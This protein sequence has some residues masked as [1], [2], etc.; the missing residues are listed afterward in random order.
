[1]TPLPAQHKKAEQQEGEHGVVLHVQRNVFRVI[2]IVSGP[3][4]KTLSH[5]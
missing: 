3:F 4:G 2:V 5:P 1:M